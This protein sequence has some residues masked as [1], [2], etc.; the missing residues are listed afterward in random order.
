[1]PICLLTVSCCFCATKHIR[2]VVTKTIGPQSLKYLSGP[3]QKIFA[4]PMGFL[5]CP[6]SL[7]LSLSLL[8]SLPPSLFFSLPPP[9]LPSFQN[10]LSKKNFHRELEL[11][12]QDHPAI[13][14]SLKWSQNLA[15]EFKFKMMKPRSQNSS[16]AFFETKLTSWMRTCDRWCHLPT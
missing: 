12:L 5:F 8:P 15:L 14:R 4:D 3:W 10:F 1:M 2:I 7:F 11:L 6:F 16:L 13:Y 9:F